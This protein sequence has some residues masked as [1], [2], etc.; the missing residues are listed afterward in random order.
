MDRQ[1][2][3]DE[4]SETPVGGGAG[5]A[6]EEA[7]RV[8]VRDELAPHLEIV[9]TLGS[10][11]A[12]TVYLAREPA[13]RRLVAVKVMAPELAEDAKARLRFEREAQSAA[14][15]QHPNVATVYRVGVLSD[16]LPY[17]IMRYVK[18][19]SLAERLAGEGPLE[20]AEVRRTLANVASGLA[21]AHRRGI[22]HRDV[23]PGNVLHEDETGRDFLTDFGIAAL[24]ASGDALESRLTTRD[25][26]LGDQRYRSPEQLEHE[27][28]T[29]QA[30]I[31]GLGLLGF[32][33]LTGESPYEASEA[34]DWVVAHMR[35]E[36]RRISSLRAGVDPMLEDLL[37]RCLNKVPVHRPV[38]AE[39]VRQLSAMEP[40]GREPEPPPGP[41]QPT[42]ESALTVDSVDEE[43]RAGA[44]DHP[45]ALEI[46]PGR[47]APATPPEGVI[48]LR[49]LGAL[50]LRAADGHRI[51]SVSARPKRV[52][53]LAYLAIG[54][55]DV[56][57]RRDRLTGV[58]WPEV[59]DERARHSLR[60]ALYVLRQGLG[61]EVLETRGDEE[62]RLAK[63]AVWCD[64]A[65]FE[66]AA[67]QGR[68]REALDWYGGELLPGFFVED[69]HG[70][71]R[72]LDAAR[73]R[74]QRLASD[75]AWSLADQEE[76]VG[77]TT[78]AAR[79]AH[80]AAELAPWDEAG[81]CRLIETLERVG[82]RAGAL[83]AY[84][85]FSTQLA[86]EFE[87]EP[88]PETQALARRL[89]AR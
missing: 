16:D 88:A 60:Q 14:R 40:R 33:L 50:D 6:S 27:E 74:L 1:R 87:E 24:I 59:D 4:G 80:K 55:P 26:I 38:A 53:L 25:H 29:E 56:F 17:F 84:E 57:K 32:E 12:A 86:R 72:W 37:M 49:V 2:D 13:L 73:A 65:A 64:A 75:S 79:W 81:L 68:H 19:R 36:P 85:R 42:S 43:V 20:P 58:F 70:F 47:E 45:P 28:V 89:R 69:A 35:H 30:D 5:S 10:G 76:A 44:D 23:K 82:D 41:P 62:L 61:S 18:G 83:H 66:D 71:E 8:R 67:S 15:I 54:D 51:L 78:G 48:T 52:A 46:V 63:S 22:V 34:M 9:R 7:L 39:V 31:Y 77:H 11:S 3:P 21:A